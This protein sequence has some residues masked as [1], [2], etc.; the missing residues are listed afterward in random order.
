MTIRTYILK[1]LLYALLLMLGAPSVAQ[2]GAAEVQTTWRLLDY[3]AVDYAGAVENGRIIS[4]L[5]YDE[6]LEFSSSVEERMG[7][8]PA[9]PARAGL[10]DRSKVLRSAIAAKA[11]PPGVDKL[12]RAWPP[13]CSRPIRCPSL[14]PRRPTLAALLPS[15]P[16]IAPAATEPPATPRLLWPPGWTRLRSPS[17]TAP[18]RRSAASS[19][20]TR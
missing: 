2:S 18:A 9:G 10:L 3:I 1:P 20:C 7:K 12:A 17:P 16:R 19:P 14:P 11:P 13:T 8:L 6:M 15:T 4:Q 5:E